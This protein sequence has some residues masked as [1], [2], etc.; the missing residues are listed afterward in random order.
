MEEGSDDQSAAVWHADLGGEGATK[1]TVL[2]FDCAMRRVEEPGGRIGRDVCNKVYR[3][4]ICMGL[5]G[6]WGKWFALDA[7]LCLTMRRDCGG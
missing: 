3:F 6:D 2:E 5:S 4:R 1:F 7:D